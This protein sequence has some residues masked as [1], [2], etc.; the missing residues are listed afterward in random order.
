VQGRRGSHRVLPAVVRVT[1]PASAEKLRRTFNK[2]RDVFS[3]DWDTLRVRICTDGPDFGVQLLGA[4]DHI[5]RE[6]VLA[7]L[8]ERRV[9]E[10]GCE[11]RGV[12][13]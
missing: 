10:Q 8:D 13:S 11:L 5:W 2:A 9:L 4:C 7:A 3:D 6:Q 1:S 12:R